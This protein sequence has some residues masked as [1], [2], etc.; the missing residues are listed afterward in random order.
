MRQGGLSSRPL[1]TIKQEKEIKVINIRKE[2]ENC[3]IH[4]QHDYLQRKSQ[5]R[6]QKK[7][8]ERKRNLLE[9]VSEIF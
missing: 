3:L 5:D 8:R 4:R 2:K 1:G 6:Y 7:K 9:L